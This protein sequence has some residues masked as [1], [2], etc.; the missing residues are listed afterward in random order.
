MKERYS[1]KRQIILNLFSMKVCADLEK[2]TVCIILYL[3][4]TSWQNSLDRAG[5]VCS[6]LMD[7]SKAYDCQ[8]HDLL[9]A[10][11]QA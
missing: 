5:F 6:T 2:R 7:L 4:S 3:N 10:K 9:L 11:L 8:P 1:S